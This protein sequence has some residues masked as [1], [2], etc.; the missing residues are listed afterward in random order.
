MS[1]DKIFK[2]LGE[3]VSYEEKEFGGVNKYII[4][5][6]QPN[7]QDPAKVWKHQAIED[8][9]S[10]TAIKILGDA[11]TGERF[12]VHQGKE[13]GYPII[14]DISDA[15]DVPAK[16]AGGGSK[17]N[18]NSKYTPRDDTGIAVGAA[19]TNAIEVLKLTGISNLTEEEVIAAIADIA[20]KI[21]KTKLALEDKL[22]ASKAAK[23]ATKEKAAE[24]PKKQS[25]IE[26]MKAKKAAES[27]TKAVEVETLEEELE[28]DDIDSV[29]F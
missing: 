25:R 16:S 6:K 4:S 28:D 18:N 14:T 11:S 12:C 9:L 17:Y 21:L 13:G 26:Q 27:K 22:R 24:E 10:D 7:S 15:K 3:F 23:T 29:N 1:D 8:N 20:E 19:Y 5:Y 2:I